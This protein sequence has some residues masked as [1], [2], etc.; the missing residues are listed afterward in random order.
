MVA[1]VV[2]EV[3]EGSI[4]GVVFVFI[5]NVEIGHGHIW[6]DNGGGKVGDFW[7]GATQAFAW[8]FHMAFGS[9]KAL[10]EILAHSFSGKMWHPAEESLAYGSKQR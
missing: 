8:A 9:C 6:Y 3:R 2:N 4:M 7:C 5:F 10:R 1:N